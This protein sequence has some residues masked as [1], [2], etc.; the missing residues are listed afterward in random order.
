MNRSNGVRLIT[1]YLGLGSNLA[2]PVN[3]IRQARVAI[4]AISGVQETAMSSLYSSSPMGPAD[5]PDYV[6]AVMSV[7][8]SLAPHDLLKWLQ[9]IENHQGRVRIGERW[10][11]R[12]LDLDI[13]LFGDEII[14]SADLIVPHI[15][16]ADRAFVLYPLAEIAPHIS[17]P[18]RGLLQ[19]LLAR[20][21]KE[22]LQRLE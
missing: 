7:E 9:R 1:A 11:P 15:G 16:I 22:G 3:Q 6:N 18:G 13:L 4:S 14:R 12:T 21:A 5:Q 2:D 10:G 8:T 19:D 20:C 17:I